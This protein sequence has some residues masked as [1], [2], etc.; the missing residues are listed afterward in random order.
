M[1][2]VAA[3]SEIVTDYWIRN[4][5]TGAWQNVVLVKVKPRWPWQ[6]VRYRVQ[7]DMG[8]EFANDALA[9]CWLKKRLDYD[10]QNTSWG[11]PSPYH[12]IEAA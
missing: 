1:E 10:R 2:I 8:L 12:H 11:A 9:Y 5:T 6:R 3:R 7:P 4:R